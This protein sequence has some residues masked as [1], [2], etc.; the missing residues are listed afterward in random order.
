M[1]RGILGSLAK[2]NDPARSADDLRVERRLAFA[3]VPVAGRAIRQEHRRALLRRS[4]T[5]GET[6]AVRTH[7]DVRRRDLRRSRRSADAEAIGQLVAYGGVAGF[8]RT[9]REDEG[10]R[11]GGEIESGAAHVFASNDTEPSRA[12][13]QPRIELKW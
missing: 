8:G 12:T 10:D 7:I 3:V 5:G 11:A 4:G 13:R 2:L 6:G 9:C 1:V